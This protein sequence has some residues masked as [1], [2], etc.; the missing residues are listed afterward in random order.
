MSLVHFIGTYRYHRG[1]Y[2][3]LAREAIARLH[4]GEARRAA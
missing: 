3:R 1:V 2:G 4:A